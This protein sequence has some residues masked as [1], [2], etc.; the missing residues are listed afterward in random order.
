M[1]RAI[2]TRRLVLEYTVQGFT[3]LRNKQKKSIEHARTGPNGATNENRFAQRDQHCDVTENRKSQNNPILL[4]QVLNN[5]ISL[6]SSTNCIVMHRYPYVK[7][8]NI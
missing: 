3:E 7:A 2:Y 1:S 5:G 4:Q 6:H 8:Y